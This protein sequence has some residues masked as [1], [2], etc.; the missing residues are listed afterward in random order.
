[1]RKLSTLREE[2]ES[3]MRAYLSQRKQEYYDRGTI[4]NMSRDAQPNYL[5]YTHV[6]I[7]PA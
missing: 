1:M 4:T 6:K 7:R 2:T 5:L 3:K